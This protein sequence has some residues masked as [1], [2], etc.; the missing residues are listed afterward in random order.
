MSQKNWTKLGAILMS[1]SA[2]TTI[3][4]NFVQVFLRHPV[5][6]FVAVSEYGVHKILGSSR[7]GVF[8]LNVTRVGVAEV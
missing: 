1:L 5:T 2:N 3:A 4:P 7:G 6:T 8:T